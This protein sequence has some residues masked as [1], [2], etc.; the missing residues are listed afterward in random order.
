MQ[1]APRQPG[2][3]HAQSSVAG[4]HG[5]GHKAGGERK[6]WVWSPL[7]TS[8]SFSNIIKPWLEKSAISV[9]TPQPRGGLG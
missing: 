3:K 2:P 9:L 1:Q 7:S 5:F 4:V 8:L 6:A